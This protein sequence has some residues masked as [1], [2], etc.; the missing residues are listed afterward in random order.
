MK[1]YIVDRICDGYVVLE[2][3][4]TYELIDVERNLLPDDIHEGSVLIFD[5]DCYCVDKDI[6]NKKR[7][8]IQE[9]FNK[10]RNKAS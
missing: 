10:L 6:E 7:L 8:S 3:Q 2:S 1:R 5:N 9:R 4:D